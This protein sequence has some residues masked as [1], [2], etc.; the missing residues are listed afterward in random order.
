MVLRIVEQRLEPRVATERE[1]PGRD[2]QGVDINDGDQ[3][4]GSGGSRDAQK[5]GDFSDGAVL[6]TGPSVDCGQIRGKD[7]A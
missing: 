4:T 2:S 6:V 5:T 7:G 3:V 1:E